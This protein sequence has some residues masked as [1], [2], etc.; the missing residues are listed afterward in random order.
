MSRIFPNVTPA[1]G[2]APKSRE[3]PVAA[4]KITPSTVMA[5]T[6]P[7]LQDEREAELAK[8][9]AMLKEKEILLAEKQKQAENAIAELEAKK[10]QEAEI[11]NAKQQQ[12]K[13]ELQKIA[14]KCKLAAEKN[15]ED[16][17]KERQKKVAAIKKRVL[18]DQVAE[19][20]A[21][22]RQK[23][24]EAQAAK[25]IR[26]QVEKDSRAVADADADDIDAILEQFSAS[27][28]VAAVVVDENNIGINNSTNDD[29]DEQIAN[30]IPSVPLPLRNDDNAVEKEILT[31]HSH[32]KNAPN[33]TSYNL[34][35]VGVRRGSVLLNEA[36][37]EEIENFNNQ[38]LTDNE[39]KK[40]PGI[41]KD[42]Q[43]FVETINKKRTADPNN[44][45]PI[46]AN[47]ARD[48]ENLFR[49]I[50]F[51]YGSIKVKTVQAKCRVLIK[52]EEQ[53]GWTASDD[54][55][56]KFLNFVEHMVRKEKNDANIAILHKQ[57]DK[58]PL[59]VFD[60]TRSIDLLPEADP[61]KSKFAVIALMGVFSGLRAISYANITIGDIM[62]FDDHKPN[63]P[64]SFISDVNIRIRV[65]KGDSNCKLQLR[66]VD[67]YVDINDTGSPGPDVNKNFCYW[68]KRY[69]YEV[70]NLKPKHVGKNLDPKF[71]HTSLF[72]M[73][74]DGLYSF[75]T[76]YMEKKMGFP[77]QY[78]CFHSLRAGFMQSVIMTQQNNN[79]DTSLGN[80]A[81]GLAARIG[82]WD[83]NGDNMMSYLKRQQA[84]M[85]P[86]NSLV[87][88]RE[89]PGTTHNDTQSFHYTIQVPDSIT[90]AKY[91]AD[92][93]HHKMRFALALGYSSNVISTNQ[94]NIGIRKDSALTNVN[95]DEIF[96]KREKLIIDS[97]FE[98]YYKQVFLQDEDHKEFLIN[99]LDYQSFSDK[100]LKYIEC[101]RF[102]SLCAIHFN[103][104][105]EEYMLQLFQFAVLWY[106]DV[107]RRQRGAELYF[108][109]HNYVHNS[110]D[111]SLNEV[112]S[113]TNDELEAYRKSV[114]ISFHR[115]MK[116]FPK[117][118]YLVCD[119]EDEKVSCLLH[120]LSMTVYKGRTDYICEDMPT[121]PP[122]YY[123]LVNYVP[124]SHEY[125]IGC[126]TELSVSVGILHEIMHGKEK[127]DVIAEY[128]PDSFSV[129]INK[130]PKSVAVPARRKIVDIDDIDDD[131]D[132]SSTSSS[133][134][135]KN[136]A[137]KV[138]RKTI[139]G[140]KLLNNQ[141][142]LNGRQVRCGWN[143]FESALFW[144]LDDVFSSSSLSSTNAEVRFENA[145][146]V[147]DSLFHM[148]K[149]YTYDVNNADGNQ[150]FLNQ[151]NNKKY[152]SNS[153]KNYALG[154]W[155]LDFERSLR[156]LNDKW[157]ND[158]KD[159]SSDDMEFKKFKSLKK[160]WITNFM[161][162]NLDL[163][164]DVTLCI[165]SV[166][167]KSTKSSRVGNAGDDPLNMFTHI[168]NG[169]PA[170]SFDIINTS[171]TDEGDL[172]FN[173][174]ISPSKNLHVRH[175]LTIN[176]LQVKASVLMNEGISNNNYKKVLKY[177]IDKEIASSSSSSHSSSNHRIPSSSSSSSSSNNNRIASSS[178]SSHSSNNRIASSS[179]SSS[180]NRIA[181]SSSSNNNNRIASSSSSSIN[182]TTNSLLLRNN[183]SAKEAALDLTNSLVTPRPSQ[184]SPPKATSS[185]TKKDKVVIDLLSDGDDNDIDGGNDSSSEYLPSHC[186]NAEYDNNH[187]Y[188]HYPQHYTDHFDALSVSNDAYYT[189][190]QTPTKIRRINT[191]T[192]TD[193]STNAS[194]VTTQ[195]LIDS[196]RKGKNS[197]TSPRI[198]RNTSERKDEFFELFF[199]I[200]GVDENI[201]DSEVAYLEQTY[202]REDVPVGICVHEAIDR[203]YSSIQMRDDKIKNI[204][205]TKSSRPFID[206]PVDTD[207]DE[208][209]A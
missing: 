8:K 61:L 11:F 189:P 30:V 205:S 144:Y 157:R 25:K 193:K 67:D 126:D 182:N 71:K 70:F 69:L 128:D 170:H 121:V 5:M 42:F 153:R 105:L 161:S 10:R 172:L 17:A 63:T 58:K 72:Q 122:L 116:A 125:I 103:K 65:V 40:A 162:V 20:E 101:C 55:K 163:H 54:Y 138:N 209:K 110:F 168:L 94:E 57:Q 73:N 19:Q 200:N 21:E 154:P 64:N 113:K 177:F 167:D 156:Q 50:M 75:I 84:D 38:N 183:H 130:I 96:R 3:D 14:A 142:V 158:R 152:T 88:G 86:V 136:K 134:G 109:W 132:E 148:N 203:Y 62:S 190:Y 184:T 4:A 31:L 112:E 198:F 118:E 199:E 53:N 82:N 15:A 49:Y 140:K 137:L 194:A 66:F 164:R 85:V 178:S 117:L 92:I 129:K 179:S 119:N 106:R 52:L 100:G 9:E 187:G 89:I 141:G 36:L 28:V 207:D 77:L 171:V 166:Y 195:T 27:P 23:S 149:S 97:I 174:T 139:N 160:I 35:A 83:I 74:E 46:L 114:D 196:A 188:N 81:I 32:L 24:I 16:V 146:F 165:Q 124:Y 41:I 48:I 6:S 111:L 120:K 155:K 95:Y 197:I 108:L 56:R 186:S 151:S 133:T 176:R 175:N 204:R 78:F 76:S 107:Y 59:M 169:N 99:N 87:L 150:M 47:G 12:N 102:V 180:N 44:R 181:S 98:S 7:P 80:A 201:N 127:Y 37:N 206:L 90:N 93:F 104:P 123:Y 2:N 79:T 22:K 34:S 192:S 208:N 115:A 91:Y 33:L 29:D 26:K 173:V 159:F 185:T 51:N 143:D 18:A 13:V 147:M 60:I 131:N 135:T 191:E 43:S 45:L 1:A 68:L 39:L 145:K 202:N